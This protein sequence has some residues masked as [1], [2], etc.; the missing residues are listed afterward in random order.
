MNFETKLRVAL[1]IATS[2]NTALLVTTAMIG[3]YK[4]A[5]LSTIWCV[6]T[7]ATEFVVSA[8][9]TYFNTDTTPEGQAG[10]QLTRY[11]K[12]TKDI[13]TPIV[14]EPS[15]AGGDTDDNR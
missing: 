5:V 6:L 10:T 11:L 15:D 2:L 1:R 8:I 4:I 12:A 3:E 13:Q 9:T 7:I 14:E